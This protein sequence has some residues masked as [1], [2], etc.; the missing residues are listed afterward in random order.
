[1]NPPLALVERDA[2][3]D[4]DVYRRKVTR[5]AV[6][7]AF[8]VDVSERE[9]ILAVVLEGEFA[10]I[11]VDGSN[12]SR[13]HTLVA[14]GD[15]TSLCPALSVLHKSIERVSAYKNGT[16]EVRFT[17][18]STLTAAPNPNYESWHITGAGGLLIVC[19]PGGELAVWLPKH[20]S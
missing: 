7:N 2:S 11:T 6:D 19:T 14:G 12:Q 10:Y 16:V 5:C 13:E 15:P 1:M 20:D 18:G 17:D 3:W 9:F 8:T 4:I